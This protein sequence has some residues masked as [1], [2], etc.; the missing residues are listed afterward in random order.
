MNKGTEEL[1]EA[2]KRAGSGKWLHSYITPFGNHFIVSEDGSTVINLSTGDVPARYVDFIVA[3]NPAAVL[4]LIAALEQAQQR[5]DELEA[6][7]VKQLCVKLPPR[8]TAE[9]FVDDTFGN[10]DLAAIYNACRLECEVRIKNAGGT[11]EG[12]Q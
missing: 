7:S 6:A 4:E 1:K 3:A 5:I 8:K 12:E 10:S 2:A 9:Y 11:V